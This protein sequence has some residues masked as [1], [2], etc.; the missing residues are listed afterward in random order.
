MDIRLTLWPE[1][2]SPL[3]IHNH[4]RNIL[5]FNV[6]INIC[7][8]DGHAYTPDPLAGGGFPIIHTITICQGNI[9][10]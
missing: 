7:V 4:I 5:I 8:L 3:Y 1:A 6:I 9:A 10:Y 2:D